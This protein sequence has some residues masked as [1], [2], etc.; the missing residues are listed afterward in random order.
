MIFNNNNI[1]TFVHIPKTAGTSVHTALY[2]RFKCPNENKCINYKYIGHWKDEKTGIW[3]KN[4]FFYLNE[5]FKRA[6]YDLTKRNKYFPFNDLNFVIFTV[7]RSPYSRIVSAY[8]YL[9]KFKGSSE[10][11]MAA[12]YNKYFKELDEKNINEKDKFKFFIDSLIESEDFIMENNVVFF[13]KMSE[14]ISKDNKMLVQNLIK[15]E[16]LQTEINELL[17]KYKYPELFL[18]FS[19]KNKSIFNSDFFLEDEKETKEKIFNFYKSDFI[20]FKYEF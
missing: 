10:V 3:S 8:N 12:I 1:I 20:D 19:K 4:L 2:T 17:T 13:K 5:D 6:K 16:N 18:P 9:R 15:F 7:I 11:T 14:F